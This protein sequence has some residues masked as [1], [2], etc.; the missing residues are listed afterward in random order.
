MS[1]TKSLLDTPKK[2]IFK[3]I[4]KTKKVAA[5]ANNYAL[6]TTEEVVSETII[7]AEQWQTVANK[8]IKDSLK[9]AATNQDLVF[10]A[11]TGVK[12]HVKLSKKRFT[13]LIA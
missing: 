11:L 13:K 1:T 4:K 12:K 9:L 10:T 6:N 7:V 5:S 2:M 8:A 3:T